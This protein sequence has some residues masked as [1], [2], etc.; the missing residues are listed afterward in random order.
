MAIPYP[1][2]DFFH[3]CQC[4]VSSVTL[5]TKGVA[6]MSTNFFFLAIFIDL[7]KIISKWLYIYM[8]ILDAT[9]LQFF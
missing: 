6:I 1:N 2:E 4:I 8:G 7:T 5:N 3:S 9:F